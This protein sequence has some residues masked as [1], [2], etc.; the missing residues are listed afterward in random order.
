MQPHHHQNK[1]FIA[2]LAL[3]IIPITGLSI[4]IYVPSLPA[5]SL[6]FGVNKA[7]AQLT[8]T[9][10]MIGLGIMQLF[11]GGI[12][13]SYGRRNPFLIAMFIYI[14]STLWI[15]WSHR[16]SELLFLRLMQGIFI[17]V[18]VVPIRSVI[19]DLFEGKEF[20][21]MVNYIAMSWSIGPI[22]APAIG[23]YLQHYFGWQANFYFLAVYSSIFFLLALRY[24]PET[25]LHYHPFHLGKILLRYRQILFHWDFL[26]GVFING[27][28][29]SFIILFSIV[30]PFL[31]QNVLHYSAIEFGHIALLMG[32]AWFL[33]TTTNRFTLALDIEKKARICFFIM[34]IIIIFMFA[35]SLFFPLKIWNI[36]IPMFILL[37]TGGTVFPNYFARA[38]A[39]FP[40]MTGSANALF[41]AF[42]FFIAGISSGFGTLLKSTREL[43]LIITYFGLIIL[44]LIINHLRK[45]IP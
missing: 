25:S 2:A 43:P 18:T 40:E 8:I 38:I 14:L 6:Y 19:A 45:T 21:K 23:G 37:W 35:I 15:P 7:Y 30:G 36:V 16:I 3:A 11:A 17:G 4:D 39:L 10:Y 12:S 5:V 29:Y 1:Y 9:A 34:L 24:L 28:L 20:Y 26:S 41:G 27:I 33:G 31:I 32:L 22:I 13:D 44:C 42:V